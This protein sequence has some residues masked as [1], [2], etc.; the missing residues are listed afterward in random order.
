MPRSKSPLKPI[1]YT[2]TELAK[3]FNVTTRAIRFYEDQGLLTPQ[4]DGRRRI[5]GT[6]D[7]TRLK[8]ILRGKR[9]GFS[10]S[11]TRELFDLFDTAHGEE[12]QLHRFINILRDRRALLKQ[13]QRDIEAVLH[14]IDHAETQCRTRL[15]ELELPWEAPAEDAAPPP[16]ARELSGTD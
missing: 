10:L 15:R 3:E 4:R 12:K 11:E 1:L 16:S 9:L 7:H 8:L 2:I 13:Q 14:E 5:Y 6:R